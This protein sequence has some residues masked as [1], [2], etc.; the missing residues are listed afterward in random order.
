MKRLHAALYWIL[1]AFGAPGVILSL[2]ILTILWT[3]RLGHRPYHE[4]RGIFWAHKHVDHVFRFRAF[5]R[6]IPL[7][8]RLV[9]RQNLWGGHM[10][11][12]PGIW[13]SPTFSERGKRHELK[14]VK[15]IMD[16]YLATGAL[17]LIFCGLDAWLGIGFSWTAAAI[18]WPCGALVWLA[19]YPAAGMRGERF[20]ADAMTEQGAYAL[21]NDILEEHVGRNWEEIL[22]NV[23]Y[24]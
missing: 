3:V 9:R 12:G 11:L 21:T 6:R 24:W 14:H 13:A 16:C 2:L 23:K 1:Y 7:L 4:G 8:G 5:L 15:Q 18:L 10:M 17:A 19:A 20:Y 22:A